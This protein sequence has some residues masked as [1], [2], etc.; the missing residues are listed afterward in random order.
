MQSLSP[1]GELPQCYREAS[2]RLNPDEPQWLTLPDP[3]PLAVPRTPEV[4]NC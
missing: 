2:S 1:L 3:F 4:V